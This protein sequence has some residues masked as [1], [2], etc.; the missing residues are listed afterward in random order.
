MATS[1]TILTG[2]A[3]AAV[4]SLISIIGGATPG[5]VP[6]PFT[7][8]RTTVRAAVLLVAKTGR[9]PAG[10]ALPEAEASLP[11]TVGGTTVRAATTVAK[12]GSSPAGAASP[13]AEPGGVGSGVAPLPFIV[14]ATTVRAAV[15][16]AK[17]GRSQA[18]TA[19]PEAEPG[20]A[21]VPVAKTGTRS[22]AAGAASPEAEL[23]GL[24]DG[25]EARV[26]Q[27]SDTIV[28]LGTSM[29]RVA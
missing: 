25:R 20:G 4:V 24:P 23:G 16:V 13:E 6:L 17:T 1:V 11:F 28:L 19:L 15:A 27:T 2:T 18:G 21:A 12:T 22:P 8:G 26:A 10:A 5:A 14:S 7:V 29:I 9:S 3:S